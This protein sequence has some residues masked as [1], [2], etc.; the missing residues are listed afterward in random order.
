MKKVPADVIVYSFLFLD[1]YDLIAWMLTVDPAHRATIVDIARHHWVNM[2]DD[3]ISNVPTPSENMASFQSYLERSM[4]SFDKDDELEETLKPSDVVDESIPRKSILK[5]SSEWWDRP[6]DETQIAAADDEDL[7]GQLAA[8]CGLHAKDSLKLKSKP[9]SASGK[10]RVLRSKRDRESGYYSS[11]ERPAS[12][13]GDTS[14]TKNA[15]SV[16]KIKQTLVTGGR[17]SRLSSKQ[18][19]TT[20]SKP[21]LQN[22]SKECYLAPVNPGL[23]ERLVSVSSDD[24]CSVG[25]HTRPTSTYSDSS[26]LSS[27]SFDLCTFD[28]TKYSASD[29]NQVSVPFNQNHS[30]SKPKLSIQ[31]ADKNASYLND[32]PSGTL[33]PKSEK[34][35]RDIKRILAPSGRRHRDS[36]QSRVQE[37]GH[38]NSQLTTMVNQ[39]NVDLDVAYKKAIDICANLR[40]AEV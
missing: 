33:T 5:R 6:D 16:P 20:P 34:F 22:T 15:K 12:Q 35:V 21:N 1:A 39:L 2:A 17:M 14:E 37:P 4:E 23:D 10:R 7:A 36:N 26:I 29:Q 11:P 25:S 3:S 32:A 9:H 8:V 19:V 30:N 13:K 38:D 24:G 40:S 18:R 28:K 31:T 27:D